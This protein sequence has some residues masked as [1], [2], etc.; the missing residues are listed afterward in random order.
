M[1][2]WVDLS[3]P[4]LLSRCPKVSKQHMM[5]VMADATAEGPTR[6]A[7]KDSILVVVEMKLEEVVVVTEN[8]VAMIG[9]LAIARTMMTMITTCTGIVAELLLRATNGPTNGRNRSGSGHLPLIPT[10]LCT[11]SMPEVDSFT[12]LKATS[13]TTQNHAT[14][15][16]SMQRHIFSTARSRI[17]H[18]VE[19]PRNRR[20]RRSKSQNSKRWTSTQVVALSRLAF[21]PP[22]L[23]RRAV[24]VLARGR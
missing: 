7:M 16:P 11:S 8:T 6:T 12:R 22:K 24:K 1:S 17:H 5:S 4:D 15:T 10:V 19:F 14:T 3:L 2:C 13:T 21:V 9:D 20:C 18:S 23:T